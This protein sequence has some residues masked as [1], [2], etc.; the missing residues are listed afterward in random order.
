MANADF[1]KY[2][3]KPRAENYAKAKLKKDLILKFLY[4][5]I[6]SDSQTLATLLG[7][8]TQSTNQ[9]LG[10]M[11]L[12]GILK[13]YMLDITGIGVTKKYWGITKLGGEFAADQL[14][15]DPEQVKVFEKRMVNSVS[16]KHRLAIQKFIVNR[17]YA[18]V[19]LSQKTN[20]DFC[21][22]QVEY[23][24]NMRWI[25]EKGIDISVLNMRKRL[26]VPDIFVCYDVKDYIFTCA[27]EV[28]LTIKKKILYKEILKRHLFNINQGVNHMVVYVLE[29][30]KK[31]IRLQEM[32][33]DTAKFD[34]EIREMVSNCFGFTSF[35]AIDFC[36]NL[37]WEDF[38]KPQ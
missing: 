12:A 36:K 30:E 29:T 15:L 28:E 37:P 3:G 17:T 9:T 6:F 22:Q 25:A 2:F 23:V 7:L 27:V 10:K 4:E 35:E 13:S 5:E 14:G 8:G 34:P 38:D 32:I 21:W 18:L 31:K 11:E 1:A 20:N 24:R 26:A 16:I 19:D 33:E